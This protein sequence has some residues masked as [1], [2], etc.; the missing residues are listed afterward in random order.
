MPDKKPFPII[1]ILLLVAML[2]LAAAAVFVIGRAK[3]SRADIPVLYA[4]PEFEFIDSHG[5]PFGLEQMK[6]K[7]T[8]VDFIFTNCRGPCPIMTTRMGE[9]YEL[10]EETDKI[11][12]VSITVDPDRDS[13][14]VLRDYADRLGVTDD[15]WIFLW[16]PLDEVVRLSESGFKLAADEEML[17]M[18]HTTVFTLVDHNGFI[19]SYHGG[20]DEAALAVL[21]E[22][23][24]HLIGDIP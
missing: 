14:S 13:L 3:L 19:R 9:L 20:T 22:N 15:R 12:F 18:G 4:L 6:G 7:L 23:I 5:R 8:V 2:I 1:L 24:R 21:K 17:P 11:Q 10:Y 16:A